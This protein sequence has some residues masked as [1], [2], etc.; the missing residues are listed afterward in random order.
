MKLLGRTLAILSSCAF[1]FIFSGSVRAEMNDCGGVWTNKPCSDREAVQ[2]TEYD[3]EKAAE[4]K[5]QA[6]LLSKKRSLFH[7]LTMK[8]IRA[9]RDYKVEYDLNEVE[10]YC[11]DQATSLDDCKARIK[12]TQVELESEIGRAATIVQQEKANQ[13]RE[14][15]N[16]LQRERNEI[17]ANNATVIVDKRRKFYIDPYRVKPYRPKRYHSGDNRPV[18]YDR[19]GPKSDHRFRNGRYPGKGRHVHRRSAGGAAITLRGS[20]TVGRNTNI[21]ISGTFGGGQFYYGERILYHGALGDRS[22][23]GIGY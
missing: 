19:M 10:K 23:A 1:M 12:T 3:E 11:F 20:G 9:K 2:T 7:E 22:S 17:E 16:R 4:T 13:L 6:L 14:E 21:D 15:A 8:S 18:R 5:E